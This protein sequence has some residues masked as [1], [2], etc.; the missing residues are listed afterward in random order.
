MVASLLTLALLVAQEPSAPA[1]DACAKLIPKAVRQALA[2][3][4]PT[5]D[6]P[7]EAD[8]RAEDIAYDRSRGAT[9]CL[10][11]PWG[12][13]WASRRTTMRSW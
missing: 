3:H 2:E 12:G 7:R 4:L 8:N 11:W 1:L 10:A 5:Y 13:S 9:G 6:L